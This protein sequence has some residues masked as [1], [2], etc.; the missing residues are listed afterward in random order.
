LRLERLLDL[1]FS[2]YA[3]GV[4][5]NALVNRKSNIVNALRLFIL[6]AMKNFVS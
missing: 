1:R 3:A 2:I 5:S 6:R 4:K